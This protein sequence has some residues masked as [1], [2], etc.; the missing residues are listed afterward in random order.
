[1]ENE[2]IMSEGLSIHLEGREEGGAIGTLKQCPKSTGNTHLSNGAVNDY[3]DPFVGGV[4][5]GK[6]EGAFLENLGNVLDAQIPC[7]VK[8]SLILNG[9]LTA[10][11]Q[12]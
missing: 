6:L 1:M 8:G 3:G 9:E 7:P 10:A 12:A 2:L 5:L 4:H 11:E